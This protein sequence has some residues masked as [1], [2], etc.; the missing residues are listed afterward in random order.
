MLLYCLDLAQFKRMD[1]EGRVYFLDACFHFTIVTFMWS[2][3]SASVF[4]RVCSDHSSRFLLPSNPAAKG[5]DL[6]CTVERRRADA[7]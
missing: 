7:P 5:I 4:I 1:L 2:F 3:A 6:A